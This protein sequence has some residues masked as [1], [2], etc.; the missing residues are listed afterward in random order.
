MEQSYPDAHFLSGGN[1][2]TTEQS[3]LCSP[4]AM[5][6][7][8][9]IYSRWHEKE[10]TDH[11]PLDRIVSTFFRAHHELN[12]GERR[13][14]SAAV[15][16]S[17]RMLRRQTQLLA[18]LNWE[19][20]PKSIIELWREE[21]E[22]AANPAVDAA[23]QALPGP[24]TPAEYLRTSLSFPD[25]MAG[26]LE[27]LLGSEAI[28]AA[29]ALNGQAPTTIRVNSLRGR[30]DRVLKALPG[31][32]H[33][34][35]SPWG[36]EL[37]RRINIH[38]Q[39]GY[40]EGW[41]EI[42][43]E[44]SQLAAMLSDACPGMTVVDVGAGAGGKTLAM[45]ALM[46]CVGT[47]VALDSSEKRLEELRDRARRAKAA[48]IEAYKVHVSPDGEWQPVGR[49]RQTINRLFG[50]AECVFVDAPCTG[51][52]TLRRSPDAKWRGYEAKQ[53]S[54]LQLLLLEQS[55]ALVAPGG[56]L[57]YVTCA[58]ERY[59]NEDIIDRFLGRQIGEQFIVEP[60]RTHLEES[61]VRA[62]TLSMGPMQKQWSIESLSDIFS[63][64]YMRTWPHR[65]GMDALFGA[66]LR[67]RQA[68]THVKVQ[69]TRDSGG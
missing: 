19:T 69:S 15:Y 54:G 24:E 28:A 23:M 20:T 38:D 2:S 40:R 30:S 50:R 49:A 37:P 62:A 55:A 43:E 61:C 36:L 26:S 57:I 21:H 68:N 8:I 51:S 67:R 59:Q 32:V 33:T 63:G 7:A 3:S 42:Q 14:I 22:H 60:A 16:G 27:E 9:E 45:A 64:P 34:R 31:S 29:E 52:G 18:S 1:L 66:R 47:L 13:W 11:T 48:G 17:V 5:L 56:S 41:Y 6:A 4:R 58:F 39:P 53:M 25:A 10:E 44:A 35:Y 46:G 12:S 65:H